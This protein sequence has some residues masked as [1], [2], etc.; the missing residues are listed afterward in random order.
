M[1][2]DKY[3]YLLCRWVD[4]TPLN[5]QGQ[6]AGSYGWDGDCLQVRFITNL[7]KT[8][9]QVSH[10]SCWRDRD[11]VGIMDVAYSRSFKDGSIKDAQTKGALQAFLI[12]D[13]QKGYTQEMAIP[14]SLISKDDRPL[15]AGES[16]GMTL[17]PNFTIG[18]G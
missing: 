5:N 4:V 1:Y 2:D 14:W 9:E 6:A 15:K 17:E 12:N 13:D 10:W 11:G 7:N 3:L 18:A 16:F 8:N